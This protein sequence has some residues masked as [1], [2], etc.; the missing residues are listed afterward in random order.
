VSAIILTILCIGGISF[1]YAKDIFDM[2]KHSGTKASQMSRFLAFG[3]APLMP[4]FVLANHAYYL[5]KAYAAE[6]DLQTMDFPSK[7]GY[8]KNN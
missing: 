2:C 5:Q 7:N 4:A 3:F 6:R 8:Y 1:Y